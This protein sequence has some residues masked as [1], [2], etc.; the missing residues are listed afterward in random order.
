[1]CMVN[2]DGLMDECTKQISYVC[3]TRYKAMIAV[4]PWRPDFS[5]TDLK[6]GC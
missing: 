2:F 1:M 6:A 4:K 5:L 3:K